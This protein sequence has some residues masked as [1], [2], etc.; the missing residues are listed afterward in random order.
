MTNAQNVWESH[1]ERHLRFSLYL[2]ISYVKDF[3]RVDG[4]NFNPT[5]SSSHGFYDE[6]KVMS[7]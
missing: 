3:P 1:A 6:E 7:H 2:W 5:K 4:A